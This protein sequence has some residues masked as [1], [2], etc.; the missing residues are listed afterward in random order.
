M[1][2]LNDLVIVAALSGLVLG[3]LWAAREMLRRP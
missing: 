3:F 1:Q 2:L